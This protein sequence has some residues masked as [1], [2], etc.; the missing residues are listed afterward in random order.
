M[1]LLSYIKMLIANNKI[2]IAAVHCCWD[3]WVLGEC[4]AECGVGT[5]N[6]TRVKLVEE[7]NGGTCDGQA[8]EVVECQAGECPS[9]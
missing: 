6:N 7:A 1:S 8:T 2:C 5:R 3:E 9:K 4:S